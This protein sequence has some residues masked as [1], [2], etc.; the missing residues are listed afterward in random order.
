MKSTALV[1]TTFPAAVGAIDPKKLDEVKGLQSPPQQGMSQ[2]TSLYGRSPLTLS[3]FFVVV[4]YY[5]LYY[6]W[7]L[8]RARRPPARGR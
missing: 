3:F 8:Y 4:G 5:V 1:G 6:S 2:V 7:L